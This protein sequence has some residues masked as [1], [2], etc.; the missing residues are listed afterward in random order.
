MDITVSEADAYH[1]LRGNEDWQFLG[2]DEEKLAALYRASDFI[3]SHYRTRDTDEAT[4]LVREAIIRLAPEIDKL[5]ERRASATIKSK[6][7]SLEGA[8]SEETTYFDNVAD[9]D[10]FPEITGLLQPVML[11]ASNGS[12]LK[13]IRVVR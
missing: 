5:A 8:L 11:G 12:S 4:A 1:T 3:R 10:P 2:D 7:E 13:I 9:S 6:K